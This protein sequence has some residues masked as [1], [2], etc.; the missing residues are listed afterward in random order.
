MLREGGETAG[1]GVGREWGHTDLVTGG[2]TLVLKYKLFEFSSVKT[3]ENRQMYLRCR[4]HGERV[5]NTA[6]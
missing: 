6:R 5:S 4:Q 3:W 2:H 1:G